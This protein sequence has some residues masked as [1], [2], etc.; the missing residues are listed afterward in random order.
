MT[1]EQLDT[2]AEEI[3]KLTLGKLIDFM[4][5]TREELRDLQKQ[6]K[7]FKEQLELFENEILKRLDAEDTIKANGRCA[8]A[9]VTEKVV[10]SVKDWDSFHTYIIEHNLPY[11]LE[12]R[13]SVVA[14]RELFTMGE[15]IPGVEPY[16]ERS[17]SLR[18]SKA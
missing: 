10:P 18:V 15:E 3:T 9:I 8:T 7:K 1:T 14:C 17:I 5:N 2:F 12:R 16:T 4:Y 6:E 13:P 11:L